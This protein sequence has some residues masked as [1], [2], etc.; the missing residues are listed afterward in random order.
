MSKTSLLAW[1]FAGAVLLFAVA[2]LAHRLRLFFEKRRMKKARRIFRPQRE[3]LKWVA[4]DFSDAVCFARDRKNGA[5]LALV[6]VTISFAA[7]EGGGMEEV[8]AVSNLRAATGIFYFEGNCWSTRGRVLFNLDPTEAI[9][10]MESVM[11]K[12]SD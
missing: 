3:R 7:I 2:V 5:P 6:A 9:D 10:R 8:E 12:V 11:E 4:C 1:L